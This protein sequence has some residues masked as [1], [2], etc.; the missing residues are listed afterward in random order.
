MPHLDPE[1]ILERF[2][3]FMRSEVRPAV[4][5][6][7]FVHAQVGSMASTLQFLAGEV[8]ERETAVETQKQE[9]F[10]CFDH[11]ESMLD[12]E[13]VESARIRSELESAREEIDAV[14]GPT[15]DI[16]E[17]ILT[18]A[19]DLLRAIDTELEPDRAETVREPLYEFLWTRV[20]TQL[21]M[22]GRED[23]E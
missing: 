4:S 9:L 1:L 11:L 20:E 14:E 23:D 22:L 13:E 19:D 8:R 6:E 5:E 7:D 3:T 10:E 17:T 21:H 16:E 18:A 12:S 2:A 15:R